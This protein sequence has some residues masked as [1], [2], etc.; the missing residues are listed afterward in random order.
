LTV[1]NEGVLFFSNLKKLIIAG[2]LFEAFFKEDKKQKS[3][4]KESSNFGTTP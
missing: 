2:Y 1:L 3:K 4:L